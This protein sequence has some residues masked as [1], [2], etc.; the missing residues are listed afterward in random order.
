MKPQSP[1]QWDTIDEGDPQLT[2]ELAAVLEAYLVDLE[3]GA[4]PSIED[5]VARHPQWADQLRSYLSSIDFL[6]HAATNLREPAAASDGS[7][8][9]LPGGQVPRQLGDYVILREVGR[10]GMGIVYEAQQ[11]SLNRRVALKVLPFAAVL[12]SRQLSR[13]KNEAQ[14]AAQL[15]HPHIVP[16]FAVGCE[17]G[18]HFYAM[19]FIDGQPLD[20]LVRQLRARSGLAADDDAMPDGTT[21]PLNP[22]PQPAVTQQPTGGSTPTVVDSNGHTTGNVPSLEYDGSAEYFARI[23][24]LG[25]QAA[26]ALEHAHLLGIVHRDVKPSNLLL[27]HAG[28]LWVTDFG[29]ARFQNDASLTQTGEFVGTVR[30]M[31][32]EQLL[33]QPGLVDQRTDLYSLGVTLYELLTLRACFAGDTKAEL[34]RQIEHDEPV[35]PRRFSPTL[36]RDLETIVLKAISKNREQRYSTAREL[37][38]DLQRFL[39][40]QSILARRPT[41]FER[42]ARWSRRH[43][44]LVAA[45]TAA[46]LVALG[47]LL[48]SIVLIAGQKAATER[49]LVEAR[50]NFDRA[51]DNFRQARSVV[52]RFFTRVAGQ[53]AT[54]PAAD[55][56]RRELLADALGYYQ[57]FIEQAAGDRAVQREL[58]SAYFRVGE[59]N[60]QLGAE[61]SAHESYQSAL[62][63]WEELLAREPEA[64]FDLKADL[65]LGYNNL[66]VLER[67]LGNT[68]AAEHRH[69]QAT[70]LQR[71]LVASEPDTPRFASELLLSYN[72]LGLLYSQTERRDE[73]RAMYEAAIDLGQRQLADQHDSIELRSSLAASYN[74]LGYLKSQDEPE[75]AR[76]SYRAAAE[77]HQALV[78]DQPEVL[79]FQAELALTYNNLGALENQLEQADAA[80]DY[81][82][83]AIELQAGLVD[84]APFVTS[85]QQDLAVTCNNLGFFYERQDRTDEA[86]EA[87]D[88]ARTIFERLVEFNPGVPGYA[89]GLGG[90]YNNLGMS[91]ERLARLDE[92]ATA[93]E[94]AIHHQQVALD[95]A[96]D[97][98][99]FREFLSKHY[100]NQ[101]RVLRGLNRAEEAVELALRR[102]ALWPDQSQRHYQVACELSLAAQLQTEAARERTLDQAA[103]TLE[104]AL[105][106]GF[107]DRQ[108]L[109]DNEELMTL[110]NDPRWKKIEQRWA[111]DRASAP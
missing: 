109:L 93:Y 18:V 82:E 99:R 79:S 100:Y 75:A 4:A 96:P 70:E 107:D 54:M 63:L 24:R 32:P 3:R 34:M 92:A 57:S 33:C 59:I 15:H 5:L 20:R 94:Q 106:L 21:L 8:P 50:R 44:R 78:D 80:E 39:A 12:D 37:G 81:Y 85:Y 71:S 69:R 86:V 76:A 87:F 19:Q 90:V 89:S 46:T 67:R 83:Q 26:E 73:A 7:R 51:E 1:S 47:G 72:N 68:A 110:R 9:E 98:S 97:I 14:G 38:E 52:D 30:Y 31:S 13:F 29:L 41:P 17:R 35:A 103:A 22:L 64:E 66:A 27:D 91:Y 108:A 11:V 101:G 16:V 111:S 95:A 53:L 105:S 42:I 2:P 58:A 6:H 10:G 43:R 40:G 45:A 55:P 88:R 104:E 28:K 23:A 49:A 77:L 60:E 61:T 48:V 74:N 36:P 56:I 62:A 25:V 102:K 84:K 65:A